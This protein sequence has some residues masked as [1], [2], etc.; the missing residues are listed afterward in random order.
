MEIFKNAFMAAFWSKAAF[1]HVVCNCGTRNDVEWSHICTQFAIFVLQFY[2]I[3]IFH[4]NENTSSETEARK[5]ELEA[6]EYHTRA[7]AT[8]EGIKELEKQLQNYNI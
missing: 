6:L 3:L 4:I 7:M 5:I 8:E 1:D 2:Y